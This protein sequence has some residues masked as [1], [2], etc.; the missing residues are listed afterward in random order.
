MARNTPAMKSDWD[1]TVVMDQLQHNGQNIKGH[2]YAVKLGED[3][4]ADTVLSSGHSDH[5]RAVNNRDVIDSVRNAFDSA[6][7]DWQ[8][9]H[10]NRHGVTEQVEDIRVTGD[11]NKMY[12]RYNFMDNVIQI[13][14]V[15]DTLGL[16]L[17][18][19]N[20]FDR[21]SRVY[22]T[23]GAVRLVCTNGMTATEQA[24]SLFQK[25]STKLNLN[26]INDALEGAMKAFEALGNEDNLYTKMAEVELSQE[27]GLAILSNLAISEVHR[28]GIAQVWN[29]PNFT[30]DSDRNVYNLL[31]ASTDFLTHEVEGSQGR[32]ELA[33]KSTKSVTDQLHRLAVNPTDLA[34]S[35]VM[36]KDSSLVL[37]L[38]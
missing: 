12:A 38:A 21:G 8:G 23:V 1:Y 10:T 35:K 31:N 9:S 6:G 18:A 16:R 19:H 37:E 13:P 34:K 11:Y 14:K 4:K 24:F 32:F 3:G 22:F 25:H 27:E 5:Y 17:T 29:S 15:K 30:E 28:K 26:F 2:R 36:K 7:L 20:S 33:G